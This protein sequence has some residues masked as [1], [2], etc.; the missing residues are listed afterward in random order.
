MFGDV[1]VAFASITGNGALRFELSDSPPEGAPVMAV[2]LTVKTDLKE[3]PY[4]RWTSYDGHRPISLITREPSGDF[5]FQT[6]GNDAG[7]F[8]PNGILCD[9]EVAEQ[10]PL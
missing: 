5:D 1:K 8:L 6:K 9:T 7:G 4:M 10:R 2:N 3:M